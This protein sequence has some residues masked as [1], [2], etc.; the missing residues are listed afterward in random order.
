VGATP[1]ELDTARA[2]GLPR[3]SLRKA[4]DPSEDAVHE[5]RRRVTVGEEPLET[6]SCFAATDIDRDLLGADE[7][8]VT[9]EFGKS[10]AERRRVQGRQS[11]DGL[12]M[13]ERLA[14]GAESQTFSAELTGSVPECEV[15]GRGPL[16]LLDP[17]PR[18]RD[19]C[20]PQK[21]VDVDAEPRK[22]VRATS[23]GGGRGPT[24]WHEGTAGAVTVALHEKE[25]REGTPSTL[26]RSRQRRIG[27]RQGLKPGSRRPPLHVRPSPVMSSVG[28]SVP[29]GRSATP[30]HCRASASS[31]RDCA[32]TPQAPRALNLRRA[33]PSRPSVVGR[34]VC[35]R[36]LNASGTAP[37]FQIDV[38][39]A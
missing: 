2:Y 10:L 16:R 15:L 32:N 12:V 25:R 34:Y 27:S 24:S 3:S 33:R 14:P 19:L 22:S 17:E 39:R 36:E 1:G 18:A 9:R 30:R 5:H 31:K 13:R 26:I 20:P 4:H 37:R 23:E 11:R 28:L 38:N 6:Q 35:H 7:A 29:I 8:L 21:L